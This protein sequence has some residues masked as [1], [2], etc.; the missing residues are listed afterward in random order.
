MEAFYLSINQ[1]QTW[2]YWFPDP[3]SLLV[4]NETIEMA[5]RNK[6]KQTICRYLSELTG[7]C[8][9]GDLMGNISLVDNERSIF[10]TAKRTEQRTHSHVH[11]RRSKPTEDDGKP[12]DS[13]K[14]LYQ[15]IVKRNVLT[16]KRRELMNG[17]REL[18]KLYPGS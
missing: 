13:V 5:I 9:V 2:Q 4:N 16:R 11:V 8:N 12:K 15:M 6:I 1:F 14:R 3:R 7:N 17:P 10:L 18:E